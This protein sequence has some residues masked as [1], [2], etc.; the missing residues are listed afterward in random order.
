MDEDALDGGFEATEGAD[1]RHILHNWAFAAAIIL[2]LATLLSAWAGYQATRW[3]SEYSL[4]TRSATVARIEA[5]ASADTANRQL[6]TD[7]L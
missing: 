3:S 7:I 4:Q 5:V 1:E 2:S 6:T